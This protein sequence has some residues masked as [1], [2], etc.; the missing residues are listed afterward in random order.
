MYTSFIINGNSF[1][2]NSPSKLCKSVL[3]KTDEGSEMLGEKMHSNFRYT[4]PIL[5]SKLAIAVIC[6]K[7]V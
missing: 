4:K 3:I 6:K 2:L 7:L 1:N 5:S